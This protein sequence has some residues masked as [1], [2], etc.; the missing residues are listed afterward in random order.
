M[1]RCPA[2][3][4]QCTRVQLLALRARLQEGERPHTDLAVRPRRLGATKFKSLAPVVGQGVGELLKVDASGRP[5]LHP[6]EP[7]S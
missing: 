5:L 1:G 3:D 6:K 4:G 7:K 2:T